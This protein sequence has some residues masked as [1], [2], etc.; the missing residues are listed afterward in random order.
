MLHTHPGVSEAAVIGVPDP[1]KGEVPKAFVTMKQGFKFTE[2]DIAEYCRRN[3]APYKIP[4]IAF[5]DELPKNPT[6][7]IMKNELPKE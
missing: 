5:I 7:K 2:D 1:V 3:L 6:G 4:K